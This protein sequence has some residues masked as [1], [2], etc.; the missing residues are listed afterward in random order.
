MKKNI[1]LENPENVEILGLLS[2]SKLN[3]LEKKL[4]LSLLSEMT[5]DEK[6][7]LKSNLRQEVEYEMKVSEEAIGQFLKAMEEIP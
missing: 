1:L 7:A 3:P 5:D 6:A 4:W 2:I